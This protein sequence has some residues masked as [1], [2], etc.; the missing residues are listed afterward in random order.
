MGFVESLKE[1]FKIGQE[2]AARKRGGTVGMLGS[3][4]GGASAIQQNINPF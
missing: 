3:G 1:G 2:N 4:V